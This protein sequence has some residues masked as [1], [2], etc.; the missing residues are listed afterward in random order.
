MM[1]M[2]MMSSSTVLR[3]KV[4]DVEDSDNSTVLDLILARLTIFQAEL[5]LQ[6]DIYASCFQPPWDMIGVFEAS[7]KIKACKTI[8]A[9]LNDKLELFS[10]MKLPPYEPPVQVVTP[11]LDLEPEFD[12]M[13][14]D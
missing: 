7:V 10:R 11:H 9:E 5:Q 14:L 4:T 2:M 6:E 1:M 8:I 13:G 3:L 12:L